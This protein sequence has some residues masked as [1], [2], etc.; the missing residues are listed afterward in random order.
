MTTP[1]QQ[2]EDRRYSVPH[3][4]HGTLPPG[5]SDDLHAWSIYRLVFLVFSSSFFHFYVLIHFDL[6]R[7]CYVIYRPCSKY[8]C[9]YLLRE[10]FVT[11]VENYTFYDS[12][13]IEISSINRL[14][15]ISGHR[16][17]HARPPHTVS[18]PLDL[19]GKFSFLF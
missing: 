13:A 17:D 6:I 15:I 14:Q 5:A 10:H 8:Y 11:C 4:M 2:R 19:N 3:G 7:L 1:K 18:N 12:R 9:C 16:N